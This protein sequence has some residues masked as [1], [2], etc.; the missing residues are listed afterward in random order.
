MAY[1]FIFIMIGIQIPV[2]IMA[3]LMAK[4]SREN[5]IYQRDKTRRMFIDK[6]DMYGLTKKQAETLTEKEIEHTIWNKV[7][8]HNKRGEKK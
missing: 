2:L 1:E 5:C 6:S 8:I 7:T 4:S 3:I